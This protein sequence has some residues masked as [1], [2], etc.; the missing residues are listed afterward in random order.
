VSEAD[1]RP[2]RV[3]VVDD[4]QATRA[5]VAA[6]L[7]AQGL[8]VEAAADGEAALRTAHRIPPDLVVSDLA[9]P[10]MN[11]LDLCRALKADP[12][13][14]SVP[15][16]LHSGSEDE[17][18]VLLGL[19]AGA[20]GFVPKTP[21]GELLLA[22][23][24]VQLRQIAIRRD[25]LRDEHRRAALELAATLGHEVNNPLTALLG[26][27]EL[28]V[29]ALERSDPTRVG[30]HLGEAGRLAT[31]IGGV[32]QRLVSLASPQVR[33]YLGGQAMLDLDT[34]ETAGRGGRT[35]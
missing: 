28:M 33:R 30:Y 10:G 6:L 18:N 31:R 19:E 5:F 23:V 11:G 14:R 24:R 34:G 20:V 8:Q 12:V 3:L 22:H 29:Q 13:L 26:H 4:D 16:I 35:V 17:R 25:L 27:L 9:M 2:L 32:S 1:G 21:D 15:V 7:R